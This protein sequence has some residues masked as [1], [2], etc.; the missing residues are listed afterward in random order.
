MLMKRRDA[1]DSGEE[2][3]PSRRRA[4]MTLLL[5]IGGLALVRVLR[6]MAALQD[7]VM[8]GRTNCAPIV[9]SGR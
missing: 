9:P 7:C 5:V 3:L 4:A 2:P 1:D 8:S 6:N